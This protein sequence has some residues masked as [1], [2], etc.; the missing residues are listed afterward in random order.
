MIKRKKKRLHPAKN[1]ALM[2]RNR[3]QKQLALEVFEA[4]FEREM[5]KNIR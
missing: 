1:F 5:D 4:P 2:I 3:S